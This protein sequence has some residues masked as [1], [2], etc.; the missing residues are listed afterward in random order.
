[1]LTRLLKVFSKPEWASLGFLIANPTT[2]DADALMK[3]KINAHPE[4]S[5]LVSL[6][7][8][9]P[10]KDEATARHWFS[11]LAGHITGTFDQY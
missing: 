7:E 1:M 5:A 4:S 3:L 2:L 6:L 11:T 9:T 10:P 8:K